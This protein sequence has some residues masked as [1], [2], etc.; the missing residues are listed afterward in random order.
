MIGQPAYSDAAADL[1]ASHHIRLAH[2]STLRIAA[3]E[4]TALVGLLREAAAHA[5]DIELNYLGMRP[6][7]A[8]D[9]RA[10]P[11]GIGVWSRVRRA[12][13]PRGDGLFAVL[14]VLIAGSVA[15]CVAS[16]SERL[17]GWG[18]LTL[19]F[20]LISLLELCASA[21]GDGLYEIDRHLF[22]SNLSLD[23]AICVGVTLLLS[24]LLRRS[25]DRA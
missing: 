3:R 25:I 10:I 23:L 21:V 1:L 17:R 9:Y 13:I 22:A 24:L 19:L 18:L 2:R 14:G 15:V 8:V 20:A 16:Q 6:K 12:I 11:S 4:P 7:G 5:G